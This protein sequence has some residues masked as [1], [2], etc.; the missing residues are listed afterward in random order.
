V[1]VRTW[2]VT[3]TSI[4]ARTLGGGFRIFG[5]GVV[6]AGTAGGAVS[7]LR[8]LMALRSL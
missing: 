3:S 4:A 2:P 1:I 7:D 8:M 5:C 6:F